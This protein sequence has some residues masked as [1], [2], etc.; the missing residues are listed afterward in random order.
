MGFVIGVDA[1]GT[2][3]EAVVL[4]ERG[5]VL[6]RGYA[7][8]ANHHQV[9]ILGVRQAIEEAVGRALEVTGLS[10]REA[11]SM[12]LGLTGVDRHHEEARFQALLEEMYPGL[13]TR[14]ENDAMA[15]LVGGT[16]EERGIVLI[17][18]TGMI[19][20]GVDD[21]GRRERAGGWG[22]KQ[23]KGNGY[24]LGFEGMRAVMWAHDGTDIPTRLQALILS[25][26]NL[27]SPEDLIGWI[28][29]PQRHV[30]D[31]AAIAPLVL[32]AAQAGDPA[33]AGIVTQA[34]DALANA[35]AAVAHRLAFHEE[36]PIAFAGSLLARSDFYRDMV[37]QAIHTRMPGAQV[38][39]RP[40]DPAVGAALMAWH[41]VGHYPPTGRKAP[42]RRKRSAAWASEEA[43]VLTRGLDTHS[44]WEMVG[45][46][47]VEDRRAVEA[48]R[49]TLP[50]VARVVDVVVEHM[51]RG[52]G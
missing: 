3:T 41:H 21:W 5:V 31:I 46:M 23:D 47:H 50:D 6:G 49:Q 44:P 33:A 25:H 29:D 4:D 35:V 48:V 51:R 37:E 38:L 10:L 15:A 18:G 16:G 2:K 13:S 42:D 43:N 52:G 8:P 28:Y 39:D 22:Y 40:S 9:G 24:F 26:L 7:G 30:Q 45:F 17:A 14:V 34:A 19:A 11:R 20:Y 12:A 32:D 1:G 27:E 36:V